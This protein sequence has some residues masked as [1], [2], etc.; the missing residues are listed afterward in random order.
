MG[1]FKRVFSLLL[2]GLVFYSKRG[3]FGLVLSVSVEWNPA[4][5]PREFP[6]RA[7]EEE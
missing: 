1:R 4:T 5:Q 2:Y 3:L 6:L 7:P